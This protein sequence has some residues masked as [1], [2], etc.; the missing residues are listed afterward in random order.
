MRAPTVQQ[1]RA[2]VSAL[3]RTPVAALEQR[4]PARA[5]LMQGLRACTEL[6]LRTIAREVGV[7]HVAVLHCEPLPPGLHARLAQVLGDPRFFALEEEPLHHSWAWRRYREEHERRGAYQKLLEG[8]ARA[9]SRRG[10]AGG[11]G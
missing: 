4:G 2:A 9:L 5:L 11:R 1:V 3:T 6:S 7:S 8:A 10:G